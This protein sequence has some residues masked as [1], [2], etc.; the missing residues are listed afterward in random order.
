MEENNNTSW[1]EE[2]E[3]DEQTKSKTK[4][5]RSTL[6]ILIAIIGI[7]VGI[8]SFMG[9]AGAGRNFDEWG[10]HRE[11]AVTVR[12]PTDRIRVDEEQDTHIPELSM[13]VMES[14]TR[15][16]EVAVIRTDGFASMALP[17][18]AME[19]MSEFLLQTSAEE[20]ANN[21]VISSGTM[22]GVPFDSATGMYRGRR[23]FEMRAFVAD[24]EIYVVAIV[25][26]NED[27]MD[28]ITQFF[29]SLEIHR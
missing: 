13:I 2:V 25:V 19:D 6:Y 8:W 10:T 11:G 22:G 29:N 4:A 20:L 14:I 7:G 15:A 3:N 26:S 21:P 27:N 18:S 9:G 12:V 28:L 5:A 16:A 17:R 1:E 24:N 23:P